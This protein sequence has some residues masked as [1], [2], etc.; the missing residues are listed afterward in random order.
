MSASRRQDGEGE[1]ALSSETGKGEAVSDPSPRAD[2][3]CSP[4]DLL[5]AFRH[6]HLE[7]ALI[8]I[9][10]RKLTNDSIGQD[11]PCLRG[12]NGSRQ[13]VMCSVG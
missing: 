4:H 9:M 2:L 12:K 3:L 5:L 1:D 11:S 6:T 8:D 7:A 13:I 10:S